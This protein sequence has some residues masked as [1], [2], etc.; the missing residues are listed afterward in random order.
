MHAV[1][2]NDSER[3]PE[4]ERNF[5]LHGPALRWLMSNGRIPGTLGTASS[6]QGRLHGRRAELVREDAEWVLQDGTNV[7]RLSLEGVL[8]LLVEEGF[9]PET[10][11]IVPRLSDTLFNAAVRSAQESVGHLQQAV[12]HVGELAQAEGEAYIFPYVLAAHSLDLT[13][14]TGITSI[15]LAISAAESQL[16]HWASESGGW[17]ADEDRL[18]AD[19]KVQVLAGR[20][21]KSIDLG[22]PPHQRLSAAVA[23]RNEYV[24]SGPTQRTMSLRGVESVAPGRSMSIEARAACLGVRE[25][26]LDLANVLGAPKPAYIRVCPPG[27]PLDES[28][29]SNALMMSGVRD[30]PEFPP[31]GQLGAQ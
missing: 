2:V 11:S 25:S 21:G 24:H 29:W 22:V 7:R 3:S 31:L 28:V 14:E 4:Q 20:A 6:L 1:Q 9:F 18:A 15:V 8:H 23:R 19:R 13:V 10:V 27:D 5:R 30:D 16:N 26:L 17:Q 12:R